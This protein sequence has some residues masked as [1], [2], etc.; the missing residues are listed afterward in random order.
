MTGEE[1]KFDP[2]G[3]PKCQVLAIAKCVA[4]M[5]E[6]AFR[7]P[8]EEEKY[9]KWLKERIARQATQRRR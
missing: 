2:S 6:E 8:A 3:I 5:V 7:D 1:N 9:Q 4:E